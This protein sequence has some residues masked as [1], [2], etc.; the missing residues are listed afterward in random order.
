MPDRVLILFIGVIGLAMGGAV[1]YLAGSLRGAPEEKRLQEIKPV[2]RPV[3]PHPEAIEAAHLWV[4]RRS[5]KL[6][7]QLGG[8]VYES[9]KD[10]AVGQND[11]MQWSMQALA[12][13]L[14]IAPPQ[15][16]S[17][18]AASPSGIDPL[19]AP[20]PE[21]NTTE[22]PVGGYKTS[23]LLARALRSEVRHP[24]PVQKSI[25][26][27]I[28]AILQE[29]LAALPQEKR[30]IRLME[31]PG[32]GMVVMIGLDQYPGVDEVPD[33]EV[34]ALIKSCVAEWED[35]VGGKNQP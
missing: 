5:G 6:I 25:A 19:T 1:G 28:D 15:A 30:A 20:P 24:V 22:D 16:D 18:K 21:A 10:L 34:Q 26:A 11:R 8:R 33:L 12:A 32:K 13:W 31:I 3:A 17:K 29:K 27:Q 2:D 9:A 23:N 4:D 7:V 14:G 35:Q